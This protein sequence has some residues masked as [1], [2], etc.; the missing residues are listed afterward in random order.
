MMSKDTGLYDMFAK[1][2]FV[3]DKFRVREHNNECCEH[4]IVCE[5]REDKICSSG[6]GLFSVKTGKL[7]ANGVIANYRID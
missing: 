6:Y 5:L 7:I 4:W 2:I 3:G 1:P